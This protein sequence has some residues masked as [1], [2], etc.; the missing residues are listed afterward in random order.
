MMDYEMPIMN[1][2]EVRERLSNVIGCKDTEQGDGPRKTEEDPNLRS[3]SLYRRKRV[4]L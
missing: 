2:L 3:H 4:V 1:G